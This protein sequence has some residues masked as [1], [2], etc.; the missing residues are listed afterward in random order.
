MLMGVFLGQYFINA[1]TVVFLTGFPVYLVQE[2]GMS[3][4]KISLLPLYLLFVG[5]LVEFQI[6]CSGGY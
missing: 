1:I 3:I 2:R 5:L 4:L 6:V